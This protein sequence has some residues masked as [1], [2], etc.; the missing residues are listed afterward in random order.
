M[1]VYNVV[2]REQTHV[3][4]KKTLEDVASHNKQ[5]CK[6]FYSAICNSYAY[7]GCST[8]HSRTDVSAIKGRKLL[9]I[10][11]EGLIYIAE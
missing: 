11:R 9:S 5:K 6:F 10:S 4:K 8:I 1:T 3:V 2:Y 7:S